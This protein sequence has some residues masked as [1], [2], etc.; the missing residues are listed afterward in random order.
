MVGFCPRPPNQNEQADEIFY[1]Q[2]GEA[3]HSLALALEGFR[4]VYVGAY[5]WRAYRG[6]Q[7][8]RKYQVFSAENTT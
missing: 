2:L 7:L 5:V 4:R 3:S 1:R 6:L 8:A